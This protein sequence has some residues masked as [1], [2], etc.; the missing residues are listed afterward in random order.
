M[1]QFISTILF[2]ATIL[3]LHNT[4]NAQSYN[5]LTNSGQTITTCSGT[6]SDSGAGTTHY[7]NNENHTVTFCSTNGTDLLQFNFGVGTNTTIERIAPG[8]TLYIYDGSSATGVPIA[9]LT[10]NSANNNRI[11][12][13]GELSS[14]IF[15]SPSSCI[16]FQFV[17]DGATNDDGWEAGITCVP[18]IACGTNPPA[19][20]MF[21]GAPL[22]CDLSGYCGI[23]SGNFGAD[24]PGNLFGNVGGSCPVLFGGT[25]QNNSWLRFQAGAANVSF[26]VNVSGCASGIQIAIFAYNGTTF[27]RMSPCAISD[28]GTLGNFSLTGTGLTP[29]EIYY[30]MVD[31]NAGDVC[32]YTLAVTSGVTAL[33]AGVNQTICIGA[34]ANLSATGPAGSTYIW[35]A[36]GGGF[37]PIAGA[38]QTVSPLVTTN[39]IV[40]AAGACESQTDTVQVTVNSCALC[41]ISSLAAG[42]QSACVPASNTY[43][44]QVIVTYTNPPAT[45][46]LV[47]NG[48]S[49]AIGSSP[50]TVTLTNL[51][52]NGAAV[53]VTAVFSADAICTRTTNALFTAPV[54]CVVVLPTC[55]PNNG[56]WD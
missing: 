33:N 38:N 50:Q 11:P 35:A 56:T 37:G 18:P 25:L 22:I 31:G 2:C 30:I 36:I 43:T 51:T 6:F 29:G 5:T 21:G 15:L 20:D 13:L 12:Y 19:S 16:T 47:V 14:A 32:N 40:T 28:G 39:Y 52:A 34:S 23:T 3:L 1:K 46:T 42:T 48:Q 10:G 8:D 55:T 24:Y 9:K 7:G 45:G 49:F 54:S 27:T 26:N 17:S 53:N 41:A 44:R 4:A